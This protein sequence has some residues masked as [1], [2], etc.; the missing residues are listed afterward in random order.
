[1]TRRERLLEQYEDAYFALLM[2]DV[3]LQEGQRL[4]EWNQQLLED[5][6]AA[7]PESLARRCGSV[8]DQFASAQRRRSAFR[9]TGKALRVAAVIMAAAS[10]L[11]TSTFA[12]SEDFRAA[13]MNLMLTGTQRYTGFKMQPGG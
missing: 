8:M 12:V 9:R 7:V 1:M 11:F 5:P 3:M 4:E 13:T 2:E 10:M 6:G